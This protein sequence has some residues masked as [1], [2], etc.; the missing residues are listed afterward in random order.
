M[1]AFVALL[2]PQI[3][4]SLSLTTLGKALLALALGLLTA[5]GQRFTKCY[6]QRQAIQAA[7][8]V[9]PPEPLGAADLATLGVFPAR[10]ANGQPAPYEPRPRDEDETLAAALAQSKRVIVHGPP[11]CGKSHAASRAA[12]TALSGTP[13]IVPLDADSLHSLLVGATDVQTSQPEVCLWLDGADRFME[14]LDARTMDAIE[15]SQEPDVRIVATIRTEQWQK[16]IDGGGQEGE[17]ARALAQGAQIVELGERNGRRTA[18]SAPQATAPPPVLPRPKPLWSDRA[19]ALLV[20]GFLGVVVAGVVFGLR[21]DLLTPPSITDQMDQI[22]SDVLAAAGPGGGHVVVDERVQF[23]STDSPSWLLV[24][25]DLPSHDEFYAGA[26][27]G[28]RPR[29]RSDDLRIYDVEGG[30]LRLELHFRP[31]GVGPT[32]ADWQVLRAGAAPAAD[33]DSDG[34]REVIAGYAIA[35]QATEALVPFGIDWENGRYRLVSLAPT[36]PDLR[37]RG[38]DRQTVDF[39]RAAYQTPI[40]FRN[41]VT[42]PQFRDLELTGYRVQAFALTDKPTLRLLTGYFSAFPQF[43][44]PHVLELHANQFRAG[45][46]GVLPC[47]PEFYA[48]PAPA[49]EQDVV[50]PPA[51]SFDNGLLEGWDKVGSRW[52]TPIKVV[53]HRPPTRR[54]SRPPRR[55]RSA[56]AR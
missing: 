5:A 26:A 56:S 30:R 43:A 39:R 42:E 28:A 34:A 12:G 4:S 2:V 33:Y 52:S 40:T 48:C 53:Q 18:S 37:S 51:K 19:F 50:V 9:W 7:L 29:P 16:L 49:A 22:K 46:L 32:A 20:A 54:V 44:K 55:A 13:A 11:R 14:A 23:H 10:P 17:A 41:A 6:K 3:A 21:G 25:E 24:V 45:H 27:N 31:R 35:A 8:R 1:L 47:T 38:L 15:R 36:K